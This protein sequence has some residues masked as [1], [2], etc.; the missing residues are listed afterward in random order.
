MKKKASRRSLQ[1][2]NQRLACTVNGGNTGNP[3]PVSLHDWC[4]SGPRT[5]HDLSSA[6]PEN[7]GRCGRCIPVIANEKSANPEG[8]RGPVR[9][10][11]RV[12]VGKQPLTI[13]RPTIA[14]T[15]TKRTTWEPWPVRVKKAAVR[16]A[17]IKLS[18][19]SGPRSGRSAG[20]H[21]ARYARHAPEGGADAGRA[22]IGQDGG[23]H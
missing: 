15:H 17:I 13:I 23:R 5:N 18:R 22:A 4:G 19:N 6:P 20:V 16:T 10:G 3:T 1:Q 7:S 12:G 11:R 9:G 14:Q 2:R 21:C 8:E